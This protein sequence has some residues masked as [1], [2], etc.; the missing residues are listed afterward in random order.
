MKTIKM[1]QV[2]SYMLMCILIPLFISCDELNGSNTDY[3]KACEELDYNK[4]WSIVDKL[5]EQ[6]DKAYA[7]YFADSFFSSESDYHDKEKKFN[8]AFD[9]VLRNEVNYL[10]ANGDETSAKRIIILFNERK[11]GEYQKKEYIKEFTKL[12]ISLENNYAVDLF[13]KN[14]T[15]EDEELIEYLAKKNDTKY[16]DK[17]LSLLATEF[18]KCKQPSVGLHPDYFL[19]TTVPTLANKEAVAYMGF[20]SKLNK[21]L[22]VAIS[23]HNNYLAQKILSLYTRTMVVIEGTGWD[24]EA[25]RHRGAKVDHEHIY[26]EFDNS[27]IAEARRK[28]NDALKSGAFK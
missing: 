8:T 11:M 17:I 18:G 23:G 10:L 28:Y 3:Q 13:A 20:N 9:Y 19:S 27:E 4:A 26:I 21:I 7:D 16:S 12:A 25:K 2:A 24:R 6:Y 5:K 1:K 15:L 22:D 14:A